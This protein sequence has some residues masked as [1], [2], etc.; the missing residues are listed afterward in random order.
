LVRR[1]EHTPR[2]LRRST[3]HSRCAAYYADLH[4]KC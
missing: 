1:G 3:P 2:G 4:C